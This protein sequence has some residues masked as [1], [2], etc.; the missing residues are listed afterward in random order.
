MP[1]EWIDNVNHLMILDDLWKFY[2]FNMSL[3]IRVGYIT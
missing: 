3:Y 2:T 1:M